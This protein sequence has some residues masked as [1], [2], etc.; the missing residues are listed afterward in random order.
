MLD[1]DDDDDEDDVD[2]TT[3][4]FPYLPKWAIAFLVDASYFLAW[5]FQWL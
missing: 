4:L 1:D 2:P 5:P 3:S